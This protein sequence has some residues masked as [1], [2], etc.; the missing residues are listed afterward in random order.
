MTIKEVR[1]DRV[2]SI[3]GEHEIVFKQVWAIC[4]KSFGYDMDEYTYE[5]ILDPKTFVSG[6]A[7][8]ELP[9]ILD[10]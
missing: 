2:W 10:T 9:D 1:P 5:Q 4:L 6:K 7:P 8:N 3:E